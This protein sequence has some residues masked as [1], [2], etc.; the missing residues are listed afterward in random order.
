MLLTASDV[1]LKMPIEALVLSLEFQAKM[2][3]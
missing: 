3:A 1:R 2:A